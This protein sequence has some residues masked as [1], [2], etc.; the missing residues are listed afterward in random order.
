MEINIE[1]D[2]SLFTQDLP[3][4]S[5]VIPTL[6]SETTLEQCL[7]S[8]FTQD[9]PIDKYEVI[10]VDG[11]SNDRTLEIAKK[12]PVKIVTE[13][14]KGRGKAYNRG[15]LET[16]GEAIA[17]LDSDAYAEPLWLRDVSLELMKDTR[18]AIVYCSSKA[19]SNASFL[20]KCID[21]LNYKGEG[22]ANGVL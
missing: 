19:P 10:I 15:V 4:V 13:Y 22:Q 20:Q 14:K 6:N 5:V 8:V 12:F 2:V 21:T 16:K 11:D 17:F 1:S 18:V 7:E 3:F 9:Y